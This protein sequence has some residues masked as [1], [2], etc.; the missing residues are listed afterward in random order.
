MKR[1]KG[2]GGARSG[3]INSPVMVGG[4]RVFGPKPRDYRFKL[5]KKVKALARKSALTYKAQDNAIVV[6]EDF[7]FDAPKTK[8]FVN[9]LKNLQVAD[10]KS[11]LV[12]SEQN[13][14]VY[15]S[16]RNLT[17]ANVIT[18]SELNTYKVLDNKAL[19]LTES[20]VAA[21]NNF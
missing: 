2:T 3:D 8:E 1:Q 11:L 13:K 9:L 16:S 7:S 6:V 17:G 14:N 20:T 10:K 5:N 18:V 15:L 12:L 21:I 19:V 4:G